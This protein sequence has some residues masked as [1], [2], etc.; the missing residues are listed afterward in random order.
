MT[1]N[2]PTT[3]PSCFDR[4]TL[5]RAADGELDPQAAAAVSSHLEGCPRCQTLAAELGDLAQALLALG[6]A[7]AAGGGCPDFTIIGGYAEGRLTSAARAQ[8][9]TH[10][11]ACGRCL[12]DLAAL[13]AELRG[14][15]TDPGVAVPSWALARARALLGAPAAQV[16]AAAAVAARASLAHAAYQGEQLARLR[17]E[18]GFLAR[19]LDWLR[20]AA[21][22]VAATASILVVLALQLPELGQVGPGIRGQAG[23]PAGGIV[24]LTPGEGQSLTTARGLLSWESVD[25]ASTYTVTIVDSAG[26]P[27]WTGRTEATQVSIPAHLTLPTSTRYAWWVETLLESGEPAESPIAHFTVTP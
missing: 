16:E 15:E 21:V 27:V 23:V 22:P 1:P 3:S 9:E 7:R 19:A 18:T 10:A 26:T 8:F 25:G 2:D 12:G 20:A 24:L 5:F 6:E 17:G 14:L 4:V 13:G 11:A